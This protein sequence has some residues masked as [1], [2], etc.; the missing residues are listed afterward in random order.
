[1]K[2]QKILVNSGA[3]VLVFAMAVGVVFAATESDSTQLE[4]DIQDTISLVCDGVAGTQTVDLGTLTA[5][6]PVTGSTECVVTT[7]A[8]A[9]YVL[10]VEQDG[11]SGATTMDQDNDDAIDIADKTAWDQ[12]SNAADG[13][14]AAYSG[15][16]LGF[17]VLSS[18]ATKN[19]TWWGNAAA[20]TDA[21]QLY[22]GFPIL[23]SANNNIMEHTSYSSTS[24]ATTICYELDVPATQQSGVYHGTVVYTATSSL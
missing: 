21:A 15:T 16:G 22:A 7:N 18:T 8:Q 11:N 12:T 19:V 2:I 24:T 14:A 1:M 9:G 20:C 23:G 3:F 5:G 4:V 13:N 6:T 10:E 17:G